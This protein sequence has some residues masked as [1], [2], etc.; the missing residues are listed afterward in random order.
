MAENSIKSGLTLEQKFG[1]VFLF[2]FAIAFLVLSF[3]QLRN[4]LYRPYALT[5]AVP[6]VL[7]KEKFSDPT[8]ALHYRDT[9]RDGLNDFEEIYVYGTSAY[10][11]DTDSDGV[12]DKEEILQGRNPLCAEGTS[13][14]KQ[15]AE[16]LPSQILEIWIKNPDSTSSSL[17]NS[18][19]YLDNPAELKK[20]LI[21]SGVSAE[22]LK[23]LTDDELKEIGQEI[24]GSTEFQNALN[25]QFIN[26]GESN[27]T[28][29][30]KEELFANPAL[31]RQKLLET[32][33]VDKSALDKLSDEEVKKAALQ[34]FDFS[35]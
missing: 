9:D 32:G 1:F 2:V 10:L 12:K 5:N 27:T 34:M 28:T 8:E 11:E 14:D 25:S 15:N 6:D 24:F 7:I 29:L 30:S 16:T 33:Y 20:L 26:L 17:F 21:A 13:C 35:Q 22:M 3:F 31:L 4:N 18:E 19:I 23:D